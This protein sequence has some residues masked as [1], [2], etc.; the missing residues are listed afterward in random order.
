MGY[1]RPAHLREGPPYHLTLRYGYCA[2]DHCV[3]TMAIASLHLM[4]PGQFVTAVEGGFPDLYLYNPHVVRFH[5]R[6]RS[7]RKFRDLFAH[8][9]TDREPPPWAGHV[10][11]IPMHH[12]EIKNA[13]Q[14][15]RH[16]G[17]ILCDHLTRHT[18]HPVVL[19]VDRPQL[20]FYEYEE[21]PAP[22]EWGRY[23]L[24]ASSV[25][26]DYTAKHA[27]AA[28]YQDVA[29]GLRDRGITPVQIGL[30]NH[31]YRRLE[32][33]VDWTGK[34]S[35][36]GLMLLARGAALGV[37]GVTLLQHLFAGV[38]RPYILLN[39]RETGAWIRY[40]GQVELNASGRLS[41]C[42][43][44]GHGCW[45]ARTVA[46][47]DG[48]HLDQRICALPVLN[49]FGESVPQCYD[50]PGVCDAKAVLAAVDGLGL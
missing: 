47:N 46:L 42:P 32:G 44:P 21:N 4:Y 12:G 31:A 37:G 50:M 2:G 19:Q 6:S 35:L 38:S 5:P 49:R 28:L 7:D 27:G 1:I 16:F 36:R 45:A 39:T 26:G 29:D 40:P 3:L 14:H 15:Q 17:E 23:A 22:S 34:T 30:K 25:K 20:Y 43:T 48:S 33:A 41:C 18:T 24:L 10:Y 8:D 13:N 11:T 9:P